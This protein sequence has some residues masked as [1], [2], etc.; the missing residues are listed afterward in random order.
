MLASS[1]DVAQDEDVSYMITVVNNRDEG[2]NQ[3]IVADTLPEGMTYVQASASQGSVTYDRG[4]VWAELG[5]LAGNAKA[6]VMVVARVGADVAP[7][8]V[9]LNEVAA[10]HSENAAVQGQVETTVI[11]HSNGRLPVTGLAPL[12]PLSGIFLV[13]AA[14]VAYRLRREPG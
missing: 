7:G 6:T 5:M 10:Y 3:V 12:L 11:E 8:T 1:P 14:L 4:L 9:I 2:V 13:V